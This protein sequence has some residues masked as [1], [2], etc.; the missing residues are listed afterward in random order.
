MIDNMRIQ[1]IMP[2]F[3][4]QFH[5]PIATLIPHS[6]HKRLGSVHGMST[7]ATK[8]KACPMGWHK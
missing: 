3:K 1:D 7:I 5:S 4:S 6:S 8:H 2:Y